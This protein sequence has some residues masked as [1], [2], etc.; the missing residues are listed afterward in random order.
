[1]VKQ[2]T[3]P[4]LGWLA[5]AAV[6]GWVAAKLPGQVEPQGRAAAQSPAASGGSAHEDAG[7]DDRKAIMN[8]AKA[9]ADAFNKGDAQAIGAQWTEKG[10]LRDASGLTLLGRQAIEKAYA[11]LFK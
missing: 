1:M 5:L 10:E 9:F 4:R 3:I 8:S 2:S 11:E 6:I 7:D